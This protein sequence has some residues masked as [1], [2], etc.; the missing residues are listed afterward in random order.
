MIDEANRFTWPGPDLRPAVRGDGASIAFGHLPRALFETVRAKW[1]ALHA[2]RK[3][4]S[5]RRTE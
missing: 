4:R 5:V 2:A 3:T 1:L